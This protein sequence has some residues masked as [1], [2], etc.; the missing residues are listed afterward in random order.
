MERQNDEQS[1]HAN[2]GHH[3]LSSMPTYHLTVSPLAVWA[4]KKIDKIRSS[5]LWKGEENAN[6][7]HCVVNWPTVCMPKDLGGMGVPDLERFGRAL[8]LRWLWQEWT[9]DCKPWVGTEVPCKDIDRLLFNASTTITIRNG[10]KA[11]FWH[12]AW[13]DGEAPRYLAPNLFKLVRRKNRT[14]S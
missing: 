12:H 10:H 2:F 6:E 14:V 8:H 9:D 7:G 4:R 3:S 11:C 13:L 5:F 1:R